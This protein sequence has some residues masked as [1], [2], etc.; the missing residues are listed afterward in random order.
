[1]LSKSFS[2][3]AKRARLYEVCPKMAE[4]CEFL[5]VMMLA[6]ADDWGRLPGDPF[7]IKMLVDPV[8]PRKEPD[9]VGALHLLHQVDLITWYQ[10]EDRKVVEI[11]NFGLHQDLKGHTRDRKPPYPA[12]PGVEAL[13]G[14][15]RRLEKNRPKIA[16]G[17]E[18]PPVGEF[19]DLS[20]EKGSKEKGREG[21]LTP[22]GGRFDL[23]WQAY[24]KKVGKDA[25]RKAFEKRAVGDDLLAR[26]L[27]TL[28]KQTQSRDWQKDGGQFIPHPASWLNAARWEDEVALPQPVLSKVTASVMQALKDAQ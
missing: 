9:F 21:N 7:T 25:A 3:S 1:M 23:F 15:D 4:W 5:F 20:K 26:M 27:E 13:I 16:D 22:A 8:A 12:C 10:V 17:G 14:R 19:G 6:H 24:P 28:A 2:T 18:F 11:V